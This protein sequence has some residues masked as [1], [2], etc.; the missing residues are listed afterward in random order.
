MQMQALTTSGSIGATI[1]TVATKATGP[2]GQVQ[3][4]HPVVNRKRRQKGI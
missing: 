4:E 3:D 1:A 2:E